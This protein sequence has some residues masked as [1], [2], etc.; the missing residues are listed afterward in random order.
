MYYLIDIKSFPHFRRVIS[1]LVD[2]LR[3]AFRATDCVL[4]SQVF[5][6]S[7]FLFRKDG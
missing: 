4:C 7:H 5:H 2:Q 1:D 6:D 3:A